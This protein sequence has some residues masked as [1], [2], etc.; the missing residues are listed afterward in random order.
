MRSYLEAVTVSGRDSRDDELC[1]RRAGDALRPCCHAHPK[2]SQPETASA[3]HSTVVQKLINAEY[4]VLGLARSDAG[5]ASLAVAGAKVHRG[6]LEDIESLCGG[7][8]A[9]DGSSTQVSITTS[10]D[11]RTT[12]RLTSERSRPSARRSKVPSAT[13]GVRSCTI[14]VGPGSIN[15]GGLPSDARG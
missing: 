14:R 11:S 12:A 1:R 15:C 2:F 6:S 8:A 10:R 3:N 4:Q 9:A 13:A 5:A 7:A